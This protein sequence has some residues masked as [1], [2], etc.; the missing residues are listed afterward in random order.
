MREVISIHIGQAGVQ[1]GNACWEL[2]CLEHGIQPDGAMPSDKTIGVEDDAYNTFFSETGAGKHVPR[3]VMLDLEPTVV[4]EV[5]TGTYR[6]LFHPEQ[7]IS[8]K[9][10]AANNYARGHYTIGKEIV[11]LCLDRIRKLADNCTGLQGFLVFHAVGGGTGSGLGSL[12]LERLSVD[13]GKKS[14]LGYTIYPLRDVLHLVVVRRLTL[15]ISL[16]VVCQEWA[17]DLSGDP[18]VNCSFEWRTPPATRSLFP[19]PPHKSGLHQENGCSTGRGDILS[20][21]DVHP[22]PG[23]GGFETQLVAE[24]ATLR[25]RGHWKNDEEANAKCSITAES[26]F[27]PMG[28]SSGGLTDR[29]LLPDATSLASL[30]HSRVPWAE[31]YSDLA[32]YTTRALNRFSRMLQYTLTVI[33]DLILFALICPLQATHVLNRLSVDMCRRF[34]DSSKALHFSTNLPQFYNNKLKQV[35]STVST[36]I[37]PSVTLITSFTCHLV[38]KSLNTITILVANI[39]RHFKTSLPGFSLFL[40]IYFLKALSALYT[41]QTFDNST[42]CP[43]PHSSTLA[44]QSDHIVTSAFEPGGSPDPLPSAFANFEFHKS[45]SHPA[46]YNSSDDSSSLSLRQNPNS[47]V[48]FASYSETNHPNVAP[49]LAFVAAL[50]LAIVST[51]LARIHQESQTVL[52]VILHDLSQWLQRRRLASRET[53]VLQN[54]QS[55]IK[56]LCESSSAKERCGTFRPLTISTALKKANSLHQRFVA[57]ESVDVTQPFVPTFEEPQTVTV[58][59]P[60]LFVLNSANARRS[61]E[62]VSEGSENDTDMNQETQNESE[63]FNASERATKSSTKRHSKKNAWKIGTINVGHRHLSQELA[64]CADLHNL[65]VVIFTEVFANSDFDLVAGHGTRLIWQGWNNRAGSVGFGV[66]VGDNAPRVLGVHYICQRI[67]I[68]S[69]KYNKTKVYVIGAYAPINDAPAPER[70]D[71]WTK[72]SEALDI[73]ADGRRI[74]AGDFNAHIP[75]PCDRKHPT[76][77]NGKSLLDLLQK[78]DLAIANTHSNTPRRKRWTWRKKHSTKKL[79]FYGHRINDYIITDK[80]RIRDLRHTSVKFPHIDSDHRLVR[81]QFKPVFDAQ[82]KRQTTEPVV[83]PPQTPCQ[84]NTTHQAVQDPASNDLTEQEEAYRKRWKLPSLFNS[85]KENWDFLRIC[86]F[87]ENDDSY[88]EDPNFP[89][90]PPRRLTTSERLERLFTMIQQRSKHV[91]TNKDMQATPPKPAP[92]MN[93]ELYQKILLKQQAYKHLRDCKANSGSEEETRLKQAYND[94]KVEVRRVIRK[95]QNEYYTQWGATVHRRF[96][97][98]HEQAG[99]ALLR[100]LYKKRPKQ[101]PRDE[102]QRADCLNFFREL[103]GQENNNWQR[104]FLAAPPAPQPIPGTAPDGTRLPRRRILAATDGSCDQRQ[105]K[106]SYAAVY[107]ESPSPLQQMLHLQPLQTLH[108]ISGRAWGRQTNNRGELCAV[109]RLLEET[110]DNRPGHLDPDIELVTDSAY[111]YFGLINLRRMM[112]GNF[113]EVTHSD[114]WRTVARLTIGRGRT[115]TAIRRVKAHTQNTDE[116]SLLNDKADQLAKAALNMPAVNR[117]EDESPPPF[118][119]MDDSVPSEDEIKAAIQQLK[120]TAPGIDG[121]R[122]RHI[123]EDEELQ[124]LCIDFVQQCWRSK[125][126]PTQLRQALLCVLPKKA[127]AKDW[128]DHRGITLLPV[129]GKLIMRVILTRASGIPLLDEQHGFRRANGCQNATFIVKSALQQLHRAGYPGVLTFFDLRKAFDT[130]PRGIIWETLALYG[131]GPTAIK[132]IQQGYDDEVRVKLGGAISQSSYTSKRGI[133]QG[134]PI[135]PLIFNLVMDRVLRTAIQRLTGLPFVDPAGKQFKLTVRAY[136]D[137]LVLFSPHT[138]AAQQDIN[139]LVEALEAAGLSVNVSKT[140]AIILPDRRLRKS[141]HDR[142]PDAIPPSIHRTEDTADPPNMYY[143]VLPRGENRTR[144]PV[145]V[146]NTPFAQIESLPPKDIRNMRLHLKDQH[147]LSVCVLSQPPTVEETTVKWDQARRR[148]VCSHCD[149]AFESSTRAYTHGRQHTC[150]GRDGRQLRTHKR[151]TLPTG[152]PLSVQDSTTYS[153]YWAN[154]RAAG[155]LLPQNLPQQLQIHGTPI[156]IVNHFKYLGRIMTRND[157]DTPAIKARAQIAEATFRALKPRVFSRTS[158]S[159]HTKLQVWKAIISAQILYGSESWVWGSNDRSRLDALQLRHLRHI[160]NLLPKH[161]S[162]PNGT[163][164]VDYPPTETVFNTARKHHKRVIPLSMVVDEAQLRF[165]QRLY[166]RPQND[167][168]RYFLNCRIKALSYTRASRGILTHQYSELLR[169]AHLAPS[170]ADDKTKW[171][172]AVRQLSALR[173]Q[174]QQQQ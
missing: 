7:L 144:C 95:R 84:H 160:T 152:K 91:V 25:T 143:F 115:F 127:N 43:S 54:L 33:Y 154:V 164:R 35:V 119:K 47:F 131:F 172:K 129:V 103:V 151:Y 130:I 76:N 75:N 44:L 135:S 136:A 64:R 124:R 71:F 46:A 110:Q 100:T 165:L 39:T 34:Y 149:F 68:L 112:E 48:F 13:Y 169:D 24:G 60:V 72:L 61:N 157:S 18:P 128:N 16:V 12:L 9:E 52:R 107:R 99:W 65:D 78:H 80:L 82:S 56:Q 109:V 49:A 102:R 19:G 69:L 123:K 93:S 166:L 132:L 21:G 162:L 161:I 89:P 122:A 153:K 15:N 145:C 105:K 70:N 37:A 67:A 77:N 97:R 159:T 22:N 30:P 23:P 120:D 3:C 146:D 83:P 53:L 141:E 40:V 114:L 170:D 126:T 63:P 86:I 167:P 29:L 121:I 31:G 158:I 10:D 101:L 14:K 88:K 139:V 62:E 6:Q 36:A 118:L 155:L 57:E 8:G 116:D 106:A 1:T 137:D 117:I 66:R 5:R 2:F 50:A 174:R 38:W 32:L 113:A 125:T 138:A 142:T 41:T 74:L 94:A 171:Y 58:D 92:W 148:Y 96:T 87:G 79:F 20:C 27:A 81:T 4:D 26:F 17:A 147:N 90:E 163:S 55:N 108:S 168:C 51:Q 150:R 173:V 85:L 133:R 104:N 42:S 73:Y 140:Q 11:D 59:D 156:E 45:P 98:G 134:C 28:A 111:V